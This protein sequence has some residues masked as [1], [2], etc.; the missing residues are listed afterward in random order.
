MGVAIAFSGSC[1]LVLGDSAGFGGGTRA[2]VGDALALAGAFAASIYFLAG[3]QVRQRMSLTTYATIVYAWATLFL[4][5]FVAVKGEALGGYP[6]RAYGWMFVFAL[7]PMIL[8][9]TII[10]YILRWMQPHVVSTSVLL[11]PVISAILAYIVFSERLGPLIYGGAFLIL[12]GIVLA[13]R[14]PAAEPIHEEQ[15]RRE[16]AGGLGHQEGPTVVDAPQAPR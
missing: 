14:K 7:V 8:G 13:T 3:R 10:N 5:L 16:A 9:H 15:G 6:A 1:V 4:F 2:L 11:E 12:C